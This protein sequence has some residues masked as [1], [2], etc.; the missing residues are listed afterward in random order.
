[1]QQKNISIILFVC[2]LFMF[3]LAQASLPEALVKKYP[4]VQIKEEQIKLRTPNVAE[5]GSVVP[6]KIGSVTL[7]NSDV[8]I[9]E[10]SFFSENNMNCPLSHFKLSPTMLGEGLSTRVKLPRT[11]TVHA[12]AKLSNGDVISGS[13]EIKVTIGGCGGG[14]ALPTGASAGNYCLTKGATVQ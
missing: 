10:L 2:S 13:Q 9:T 11:T 12:I 5:E 1:M 3:N 8:H 7:P 6:I 14:G 4:S